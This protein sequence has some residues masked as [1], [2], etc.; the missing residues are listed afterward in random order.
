M[1]HQVPKTHWLPPHREVAAAAGEHL[2]AAAGCSE[3][4][5]E[6]AAA[7]RVGWQALGGGAP[8]HVAAAHLQRLLLLLRRDQLLVARQARLVVQPARLL[9]NLLPALLRGPRCKSKSAAVS[10][11]CTKSGSSRSG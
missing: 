10:K 8:P 5:A 6:G 7:V 4:A 11:A 9:P 2:A 1:P 3:A